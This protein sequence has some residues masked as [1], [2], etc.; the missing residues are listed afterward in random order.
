MKTRVIDAKNRFLTSGGA[1]KPTPV[2]EE[3]LCNTALGK[4]KCPRL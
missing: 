2:L 3:C 1:W 4:L